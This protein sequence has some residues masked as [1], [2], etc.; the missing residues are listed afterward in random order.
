MLFKRNEKRLTDLISHKFLHGSRKSQTQVTSL[1]KLSATFS[2]K[3]L[4][5][6]LVRTLRNEG[7][8]E[9]SVTENWATDVALY[10]KGKQEMT[11]EKI[12]NLSYAACLGAQ[13]CPTL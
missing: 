5:S 7:K 13:S 10:L 8:R 3:R 12:S 4:I 1:E 11:Y 2:H 6:L 9:N